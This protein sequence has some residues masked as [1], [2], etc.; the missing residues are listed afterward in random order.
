MAKMKTT[1]RMGFST[2]P[3]KQ[4]FSKLSSPPLSQPTATLTLGSTSTAR[5]KSITK[6]K[7]NISKMSSL[8]M[9]SST[10][11]QNMKQRKTLNTSR[12][13][14]SSNNDIDNVDDVLL[15]EAHKIDWSSASSILAAL[16]LLNNRAEYKEKSMY[17]RIVLLA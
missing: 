2:P 12:L 15:P 8:T 7:R 3:S 17:E 10:S 11:P 14:D 16:V 13:V 6:S 1:T 4:R 5:T 9:K